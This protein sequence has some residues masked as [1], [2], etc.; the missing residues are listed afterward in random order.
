VTKP[1]L[2]IVI[3]ARDAAIDQIAA[4]ILPQVRAVGG[5]LV[6]AGL[7]PALAPAPG[8]VSI[9]LDDRN[10]MHLR[11][12]AIKAARAAIVAIGEDHSIPAADWCDAVLRAHVEHP[13]VP[14]V[15]G[16]L[17]NVTDQTVGGRA[18]FIAFAAP[19]APPMPT[20]P[21]RPPPVSTMSFKREALQNLGGAGALESELIPR[22]FVEDQIAVDDR[23]VADHRQDCGIVWSM[24][25]AFNGARAGYGYESRRLDRAGHRRVLQWVVTKMQRVQWRAMR[26]ALHKVR[27]ERRDLPGVVLIQ[28]A[29]VAGAIVGALT[30]PGRSPERVA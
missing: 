19:Y 14:A 29:G 23:I 20:L 12:L 24:R 7:Q 5:E 16:C 8:L 10:L 21:E 27:F 22:L 26:C 17:L 13:E 30:G 18:N 2:S 9:P 28:L 25:N 6:V 3:G 11:W 1:T 15:A 4:A